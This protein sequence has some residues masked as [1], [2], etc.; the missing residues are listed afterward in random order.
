MTIKLDVPT[1]VIAGVL[2]GALLAT[3][4]TAAP[5]IIVTQPVAAST[6]VVEQYSDGKVATITTTP[7]SISMQDGI[8]FSVTQISNVPR[9]TVHQGVTTVTTLP[10]TNQA[11]PI[12]VVTTPVN[13]VAQVLT[14]TT[15]TIAINNPATGPLTLDTLQL[16][17]VFSTPGIVSAQTK[18]MKILKNSTG[19]EFAV[20]AN[21]VV[22]GDVIEYHTTYTNTSA[23]PIHQLNATVS[24][25]NGVNL[26][27]LN[28]P[29]PT[30]ATTGGGRYQT[31]QQMGNNVVI[32]EAY[33]GLQWNLVNLAANTP[34]TV[35]IRAKVQ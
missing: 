21:H 10:V 35:I 11:S 22:S 30:L 14:M 20:P 23:Q 6:T 8:P 2:T 26:V 29:L 18:V 33:S 12:T 19:Q 24:L 34:Q 1:S 31:I 25:P 16:K 27:S 4:A 15:N 17:P 3:S 28:S 7:N 13:T 5:K 32:Q 9:H